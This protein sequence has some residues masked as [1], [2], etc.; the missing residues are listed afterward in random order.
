M[1]KITPVGP[2]LNGSK[3]KM[4]VL[5]WPSQSPDLKLIE[6]LW[7]DLKHPIHPGISSS[8]AELKHFFK[9]EWAKVPP[10]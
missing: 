6:I 8:V 2:A 3:N 7:D 1:V 4:K 10:Q 9:E 5:D